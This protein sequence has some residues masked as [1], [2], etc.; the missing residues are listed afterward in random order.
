MDLVKRYHTRP[1]DELY[2]LAVDPFEEHNLATFPEHAERM[3]QM[4]EALTA[5]MRQTRDAALSD[6]R[7]RAE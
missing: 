5:W 1:A 7:Q 2:D 4:R 3:K 6:S